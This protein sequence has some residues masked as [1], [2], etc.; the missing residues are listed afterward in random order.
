MI[1]SHNYHIDK[2]RPALDS[3][4]SAG[5]LLRATEAASAA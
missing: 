1:S 3:L 2:Q 4:T 5:F